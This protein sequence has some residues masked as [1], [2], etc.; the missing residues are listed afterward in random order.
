[1]EYYLT[2]KRNKVLI[3]AKVGK[4]L[5]YYAKRKKPVTYYVILFIWNIQNIKI[6][7]L[8]SRLM[9]A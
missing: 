5:D 8:K 4:N 9:V 2:A 3:H 6:D 7:R 1:M